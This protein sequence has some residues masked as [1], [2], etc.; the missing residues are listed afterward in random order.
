MEFKIVG[1]KPPRN[2]YSIG[3]DCFFVHLFTYFLFIFI[4]DMKKL[5]VIGRTFP[6]PKTTAAGGHMMDI[7]RFFQKMEYQI[8]FTSTASL[9][10][11]SAQLEALDIPLQNIVLNDSSFDELLIEFQADVVLFDRF[12]TEEQ[13]GWRVNEVLPACVKILD[14][15]D[16]HFLRHARE[17]AL[18]ANESFSSDHLYTDDAKREL[19]SILRCD[20]SLIVSAFEM[21]LLQETFNIPQALLM[22]LPLLVDPAIKAENLSFTERTHFISAGN[23]LHAPNL[24]AV[25]FLK[26][27][28]WPLIRAQLPQAELHIYGAYAPEHIKQ[29]HKPSEGFMIEGWIENLDEVMQNARICL[30]PIR[31]GAGL[32]GKLMDAMRNGLPMVSTPVGVEAMYGE[33]QVPGVVANDADTIAK[34]AVDLYTNQ[35]KWESCLA[36]I[37]VILYQGFNK[38]HFNQVFEARLGKLRLNLREH[39]KQHFF[40]QILQHE[41]LLST[42]YL[43]KWIEE[44]NR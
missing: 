33:F 38:I 26:H 1:N 21:N 22:Y 14:T 28:I 12:I 4:F 24:D 6:E 39:R 31:F 11:H 20:L 44:K 2:K 42:K 13:F 36:D 17:S 18:K 41:S 9:S 25:K 32:K 43:S 10:E 19:A 7:L 27:E 37:H 29:M 16:L 8:I 15:E 40:G 30:A 35:S 3:I 23:F 34:A 5:L